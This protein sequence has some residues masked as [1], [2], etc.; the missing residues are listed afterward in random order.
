MF[1]AFVENY[2]NAK[3]NSKWT[4]TAITETQLIPTEYLDYV[5]DFTDKETTA[6]NQ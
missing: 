4:Q 3:D 5:V 6:E 2:L 1:N